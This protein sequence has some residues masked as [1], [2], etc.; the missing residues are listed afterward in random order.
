MRLYPCATDFLAGLVV[1]L[2]LIGGARVVAAP[3]APSTSALT[4]EEAI[5]CIR[6]A[7]AAQTGLVKEVEGDDDKGT[8]LCAVKSVD[9]AGKRQTLHVDVQTNAVVKA[10]EEA[11]GGGPGRDVLARRCADRRQGRCAHAAPPC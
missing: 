10:T 8:R 3:T 4:A 1:T 9:E 2:L 6:T 5:A 11:H 7:V